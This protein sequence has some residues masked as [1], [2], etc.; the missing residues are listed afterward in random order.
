MVQPHLFF[1]Q[2]KKDTYAQEPTTL[3]GGG[4]KSGARLGDG[5]PGFLG[6]VRLVPFGGVSLLMG[7][8]FVGVILKG[9]QGKHLAKPVLLSPPILRD[10]HMGLSLNNG[11]TPGA[12][13]FVGKSWQSEDASFST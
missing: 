10:T 5:N 2:T 13:F 4:A 3:K 11:K 9:N 7:E 1:D 12:L 6:E 8:Q